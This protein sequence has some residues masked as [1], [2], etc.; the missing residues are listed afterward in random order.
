M[1]WIPSLS[2]SAPGG[3]VGVEGVGFGF[4]TL[5]VSGVEVLRVSNVGYTGSGASCSVFWVS[6]FGFSSLSENAP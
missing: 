6:G 4:E 2:E 1:P 3:G 5:S